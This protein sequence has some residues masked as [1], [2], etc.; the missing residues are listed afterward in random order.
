MPNSQRLPASRFQTVLFA[1]TLVLSAGLICAGSIESFAQSPCKVMDPTGTPLNVRASPN[2]HIV[3]TLQN[4]VQ[5][6]VL[7]RAVDRKKQAWVYVG[8]SEDQSP[9]GWVYRDFIAC[10]SNGTASQ[11]A[12]V[13]QSHIKV[14]EHFTCSGTV[15]TYSTGIADRSIGSGD[16]MCYFISESVVGR[17]ILST[18]GIG[19][20]CRVL[21][22]VKNDN[23]AGDWS[24][25][26][27]D[28]IALIRQ[29]FPAF[30]DSLCF[31]RHYDTAHLGKHPD[32]LVTSMTLALDLDGPVARGSPTLDEG[33]SKIPFD[34]K[35]ATTKRGDNNLYVQEG[36]VE[37]RDG[38]YRG[39]VECDGGGFILRKAPSGVL[40]S[41]GLG[42]GNQ[43]IRMAIVPDPC[44]ES[45]RINNSVDIERG[46]DDDTFRLDAVSTQVCSRLFDK[47]DWEAVGRQN[48]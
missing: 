10:K 16:S 38:K 13:E 22:T 44:G 6:S 26:I 7:D 12:G 48:Q 34:F 47:I 4:G 25:T 41:I 43:S 30:A 15:G 20:S 37:N 21:G 32:Q 39:V 31:D 11:R 42:A 35:I 1:G 27:V 19:L 17:R 28:V 8:H 24:P 45:D 40:L 3:G 29:R 46:K 36:Y 9:I 2:G 14:F 33:R 18:C 23:D 5:V